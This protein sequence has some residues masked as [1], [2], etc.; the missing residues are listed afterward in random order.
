MLAISADKRFLAVAGNPNVR[1]FDIRESTMQAA[2]NSN[3]D[4]DMSGNLN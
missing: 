2:L 3:T 4:I 1:V